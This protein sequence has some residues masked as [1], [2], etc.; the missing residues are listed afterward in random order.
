M[1]TLYVSRPL[2]N[3]DELKEWAKEH[4][5]CE[6]LK[7]EDMH[8]TVAFSKDKVDWNELE[9]KNT[10][11]RVG[12]E[13]AYP[14]PL[15]DKG[16]V[17]LKFTSGMLKKRWKEFCDNG[18]SWDYE[19]YQPHVTVT[20]SYEGDIE[21]LKKVEPFTGVFN[22]GPEIFKEVDLDWDKKIEED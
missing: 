8:V 1:K 6:S 20:Y 12:V 13:K 21:K 19:D 7:A 22:F 2:I 16:A 5:N 14:E 3:A 17:V 9:P 11:L 15:G 4:L 18:A 10:E